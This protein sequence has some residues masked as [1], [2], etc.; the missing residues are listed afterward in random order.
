MLLLFLILVNLFALPLTRSDHLSGISLE[1]VRIAVIGSGNWGTAVA[2]RIAL[3]AEQIHTTFN[4]RIVNKT[5][6][7]WVFEEVVDGRN[8]TDIINRDHVNIKYLPGIGLPSGVVALKDVREAV[9]DADVLLFVVP[10]QFLEGVLTSM[11]GHTKPG[12]VGVSLI[13]GV[14]F[15]SSGPELYSKTI[16]CALSLQHVA[17]V[18]GANVAMDGRINTVQLVDGQLVVSCNVCMYMY[19]LSSVIPCSRLGYLCRDYCCC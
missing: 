15:T 2:R 17:V 5:V 19:I 18:M 6:N 1:Q 12:A 13:K 3:N 4:Q 8:L 10:H 9:R 7:M 14:T 11:K 16:R